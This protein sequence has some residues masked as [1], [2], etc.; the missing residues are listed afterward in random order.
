MRIHLLKIIGYP[1]MVMAFILL[2]LCLYWLIR[3]Y[4]M[5]EVAVPIKLTKKDLKVGE[6]ID[7][8]MTYCKHA[9]GKAIVHRYLVDGV[10]Y[11]LPVRTTNAPKGCNIS[12]E[13]IKVPSV[14]NGE[15]TLKIV[16]EYDPNPIRTIKHEFETEKFYISN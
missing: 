5:I 10:I 12:R 1:I 9:E 15:Y 7:A 13:T 8:E 14:P 6:I 4:N 3:P 16:I 11:F 2:C